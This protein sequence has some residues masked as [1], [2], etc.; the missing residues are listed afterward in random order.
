MGQIHCLSYHC[1]QFIS[2]FFFAIFKLNLPETEIE[3]GKGIYMK[4]ANFSCAIEKWKKWNFVVE[5]LQ[6]VGTRRKRN[7]SIKQGNKFS[8]CKKNSN[9]MSSIKERWSVQIIDPYCQALL[10]HRGWPEIQCWCTQVSK[11]TECNNHI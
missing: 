2:T 9:I 5:K 4:L 6:T 3:W 1:W 7:F 10:Q 11:G 8:K